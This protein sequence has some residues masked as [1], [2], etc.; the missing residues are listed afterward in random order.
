MD[1]FS[2]YNVCKNCYVFFKKNQKLMKKRPL[3]TILGIC[4]KIMMEL[5]HPDSNLDLKT[6]RQL[7]LLT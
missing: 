3:K 2:R 6:L 1:I 5:I 4:W 7:I